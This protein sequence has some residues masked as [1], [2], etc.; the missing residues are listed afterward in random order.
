MEASIAAVGFGVPQT[1]PEMKAADS[2]Q[3]SRMSEQSAMAQDA[4]ASS[5]WDQVSEIGP[6]PLCEGVQGYAG[7]GAN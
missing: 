7:I 5:E 6:H 4:Q 2:S 1:G 3:S